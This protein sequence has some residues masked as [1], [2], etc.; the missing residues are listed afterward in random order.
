MK[1]QLK[2]KFTGSIQPRIVK[3]AD[4]LTIYLNSGPQTA[5]LPAGCEV[6]GGHEPIIIIVDNQEVTIDPG[7]PGVMVCDAD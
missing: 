1:P 7:D 5:D 3:S 4:H 6:H 2:I